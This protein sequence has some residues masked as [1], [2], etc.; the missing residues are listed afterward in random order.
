MSACRT[1]NITHGMTNSPEMRI[2]IDMRRRCHQPQR[3]DFHNY[4]GR[5]IYV[6]DRWR[7]SFAAFYE[8]MGPRPKGKTLD[9]MDNDGPY[10]PENC[11]WTDA[12]Q[13]GMNRRTNVRFNFFG[14]SMTLPE[15][16][17]KYGIKAATL[18]SRINLYGWTP[19]EAV[20]EPP[21]A[22]DFSAK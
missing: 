2:W 6:C 1:A 18:R 3:P 8:D 14:V 16:A 17:Q 21:R 11:T 4:G 10:S 7:E 13:Q 12:V 5:G 15:A 19:D 9:R 20:S 22:S